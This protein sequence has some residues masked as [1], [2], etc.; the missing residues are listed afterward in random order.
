MNGKPAEALRWLDDVV[1]QE[2]AAG[3][4]DTRHAASLMLRAAALTALGRPRE[5]AEAAQVS[6]QIWR[7]AGA[8]FGATGQI[9]LARAQLNEA[10]AWLAAGE[11]DRAGPLVTTAEKLLQEHHAAPHPEQPLAAVIR[12]QWLRAV[13]RAGEAEGVEREARSRY[14]ELAGADAPRPVAAVL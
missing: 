11:P 14:R 12:A 4:K 7:D 6:Q 2:V 3:Q 9:G 13:G 1:A 10:I 8:S 5:G